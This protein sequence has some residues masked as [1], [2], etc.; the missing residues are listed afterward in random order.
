MTERQSDRETETERQ[1]QSDRETERQRDRVTEGIV[2][3]EIIS[4]LIDSMTIGMEL[5]S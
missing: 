2:D 1:R 4:L 3:G 5:I